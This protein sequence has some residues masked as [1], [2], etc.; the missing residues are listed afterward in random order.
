[1]L[2]FQSIRDTPAGQLLRQLG[3]RTTLAYAEESASFQAPSFVSIRDYTPSD[4]TSDVEDKEA[5]VEAD[6]VQ[7][8]PT[9]TATDLATS[10]DVITRT[11]SAKGI[12]NP[13]VVGWYSDKDIDNPRNWSFAKK[14]WVVVGLSLYT[15]VVYCT[16]SI[17]TPLHDMTMVKYGVSE[18]VV[19]LGLSMYVLG[20]AIGPMFLSPVSEIPFIGR[21]I[22]YYS[23]FALFF[24]ISII[25]C[26]V[27]NF[28]AM[29]VLRFLQGLFGSTPLATGAATM[30]D[31]YDMYDAPYGYIWW[32]ASMYCGPALG[33]LF[34]GYAVSD[35]WRWPFYETVIMSFIILLILP[36]LPE[37]SPSNI[38]LRRAKRL[39]AA[40][41]NQSYLAASEL[42]PLN[43]G[44]TLMDALNKPIVISILDPAIAYACVYGAIVYASYYSFF[45]VFPIVYLEIYQMSLGGMGLIFLSLTIGCA[46]GLVGYF[47]YLKKYFIPRARKYHE[48][49]KKPV[50]HEEWL[51]PG[52]VGVWGVVA[53]LL[54]FAWTA[55]ESVHY[56]VPTIGIAIWSA[57]S[58]IVFQSLVCYIPLT[59]PK[60]VASLFAANDL[61][62]SSTAAGFVEFTR[63]MYLDLGV[64][65]GVTVVA[66]LS[67]LGL[68]GHFGLFWF[69][70]GLRA[71][72]KFTG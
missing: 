15:F 48:V 44:R 16:A 26:V 23:S 2:N 4:R 18:P 13:I 64:G 3:F 38:L 71:R 42:K 62:R 72:S 47:Y 46:V 51:R 60:Y 68:I 61:V 59:Y 40:T 39:R 19:S 25:L 1:M 22:P 34:A 24:L 31:I 53:G 57:T 32:I 30:E 14:S 41:G 56:I 6:A 36:F 49:N 65:K 33:P 10:E 67:A 11:L 69:G 66:G 7:K 45:E 63:Y 52:L 55:R 12:D 21:N 17:I 58:F 20:Y 29:I 27:D 9:V 8:V 28:P 70:K 5:D 37:T 50:E 43:F 54:L 35:N